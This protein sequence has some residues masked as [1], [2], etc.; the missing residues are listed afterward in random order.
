[1]QVNGKVRDRFE[2]AAELPEDELIARAKASDKVQAHLD[3]K[4]I[5]RRSSSRTSS[6]TSS[7]A[8]RREAH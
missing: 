2:V 4:E 3:G 1:M 5:R 6:S 7:S 8:E